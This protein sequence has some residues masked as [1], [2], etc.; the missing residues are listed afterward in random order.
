MTTSRITGTQFSDWLGL[1]GGPAA[2]AACTQ[3]GQILPLADCISPIRYSAIVAFSGVSIALGAGCASWV[4][5][6]AT[7]REPI[8]K[9]V[10]SIS[11]LSALIFSYALTLQGIAALVM[12]GCER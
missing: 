9:F 2:W 5:S 11:C 6:R 4:L 3:A 12:T 7:A 10:A 8:R 1:I